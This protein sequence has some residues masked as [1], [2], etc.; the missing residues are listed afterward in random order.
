MAERTPGNG[1][2]PPCGPTP[3]APKAAAQTTEYA[4]RYTEHSAYD[5]RE[6]L[7]TAPIGSSADPAAA[8][9]ALDRAAR[10]REYQAREGLPVDAVAVVCTVTVTD[11]RPVLDAE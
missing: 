10:T 8:Q 7:C 9:A 4:I 11:W 6:Y 1:P 2:V 3:E 5:G